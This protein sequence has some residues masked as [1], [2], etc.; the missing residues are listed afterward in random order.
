MG[1][2]W[3]LC[4]GGGR[5]PRG[6][7]AEGW[8]LTSEG[9]G[10]CVCVQRLGVRPWAA[11]LAVLSFLSLSLKLAVRGAPPAE[12]G[13][14]ERRE[15]ERRA[16]A[17]HWASDRVQEAFS[18]ALVFVMHVED[19]DSRG[20]CGRWPSWSC[21]SGTGVDRGGTGSPSVRGKVVQGKAVV[22]HWA[23]CLQGDG[24]VLQLT[25]RSISMYDEM[26]LSLWYL[27]R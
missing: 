20:A 11:P 16:F 15:L 5:A 21:S 8:A 19:C 7:G 10:L 13:G 22:L 6:E 12:C 27:R 1:P 14:C 24:L 2:S 4:M 23:R 17:H 3:A 18:A 25:E 9:P 26:A